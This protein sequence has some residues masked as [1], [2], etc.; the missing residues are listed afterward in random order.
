[1]RIIK[2]VA[3]IWM[4][5]LAMSGCATGSCN[6]WEVGGR[7]QGSDVYGMFICKSLIE[8]YSSNNEQAIFNKARQLLAGLDGKYSGCVVID[9][10]LIIYTRTDQVF[11]KIDCSSNSE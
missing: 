4:L 3:I 5:A 7:Y 8:N 6:T 11:L 9:D 10:S 2:V 1:M